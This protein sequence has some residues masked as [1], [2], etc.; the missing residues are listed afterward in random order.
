MVSQKV[1]QSGNFENFNVTHTPCRTQTDPPSSENLTA[2]SDCLVS[3]GV[4]AQKLDPNYGNS[5]RLSVSRQLDNPVLITEY[6]TQPNSETDEGAAKKTRTRRSQDGSTAPTPNSR[7]GVSGMP[8]IG[9][10]SIFETKT[11]NGKTVW[12]ID[13]TVGHDFRGKRKRVRRTAHSHSDAI[14]I[15]RKMLIELEQ[16]T[17]GTSKTE[18]FQAYAQW[19]LENVKTLRVRT[20]TLTDYQDRLNRNVYPAFGSRRLA[21]ITARDIEEWLVFLARQNKATATINGS[22]QVLGAVL[23]HAYRQGIIAKNPALM[24]SRLSRTAERQTS[25]RH[26]WTKDETAL[27]LRMAQDTPLDLFMHFALIFGL[28][29]GEIL[30]LQWDD[31]D[32]HNAIIH[33]RRTLKEERSFNSDG[34]ASVQIAHSLPKA[35][36]SQRKLFL[37]PILLQAIQRHRSFIQNLQSQAGD[38]WVD[39]PYVFQSSVGTPV[40]PSNMSKA[41]KKS[42]QNKGLREIRVHDMRHTAA[43]LGLEAGV[44]LEA[45]SQ[46]LGHSRIDIT[47]SVYAPYVQPLMEEFT[48]GISNYLTPSEDLELFDKELAK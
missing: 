27:A 3:P 33:I 34:T 12:K 43:V 32:F 2:R 20:S 8:R 29:R 18:T 1:S 40:S 14:R 28:R 48:Q 45:V 26:P 23:E 36:S 17:L 38:R 16:G 39:T 4:P 5:E 44:R 46:G 35:K 6:T 21:D 9:N 24:V 7:E 19:W 15:Q 42:V 30:G 47:K 13:V 10:G 41:F 22:K 25:V 31:F 11:P 37:T